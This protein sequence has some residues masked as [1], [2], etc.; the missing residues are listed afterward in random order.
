MLCLCFGQDQEK[1]NKG[2]NGSAQK[3]SNQLHNTHLHNR[4]DGWASN[5]V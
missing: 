1:R 3:T 2:R 4:D 5:N